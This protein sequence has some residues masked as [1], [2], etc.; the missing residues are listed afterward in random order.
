LARNDT[1]VT[2]DTIVL[3][4]TG[5]TLLVWSIVSFISGASAKLGVLGVV[6]ANL[7]FAA[8]LRR[9]TAS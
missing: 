4:V 6:A 2:F 1:T 3:A 5:F 8:A 9:S 7:A